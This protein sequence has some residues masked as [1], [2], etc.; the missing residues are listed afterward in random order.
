MLNININ[1]ITNF[2]E[3]LSDQ[4]EASISNNTLFFP[5]NYGRG[6]IKQVELNNGLIFQEE[7]FVIYEDM[8]LTRSIDKQENYLSLYFLIHSPLLTYNPQSKDW[9]QQKLLFFDE[10]YRFNQY[11]PAYLNIHQYHLFIHKNKL[12]EICERY[13][14]PKG[15]YE[16][17]LSDQR[18][19]FQASHSLE[20]RN[21]IKQFVEL[22]I[23][24]PVDK[25][26]FHQ[27]LE[28]LIL[29][30]L[31]R[32]NE[33]KEG[34]VNKIYQQDLQVVLE[35][36][37]LLL[38]DHENEM[39]IQ[40]ITQK[41]AIGERKLQRLFKSHF[42]ESMN[43]YRKRMKLEQGRQMLEQGL[44]TITE[45]SYQLGYSSPSHF[46]KIFKDHFGESPN[47]II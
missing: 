16:H 18:W 17:Y 27:N 26:L 41:Y 36:G 34:R 25:S 35:V 22:D 39:T 47:S 14:F 42:G 44:F 23:E 33:N 3:G 15:L 31:K 4:M 29:W 5:S 37:N 20:I 13:E 7:K 8:F 32:I 19:L 9:A 12:N 30:S 6:F 46:S 2:L 21:L 11:Y 45:V 1:S 24:T 10:D 38:Q 43:S 40:E 28:T